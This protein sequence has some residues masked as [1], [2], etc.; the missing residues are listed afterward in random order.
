LNVCD[1]KIVF[2]T[3]LKGATLDVQEKDGN[4]FSLSLDSGHDSDLGMEGESG[5]RKK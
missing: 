2:I 5:N 4:I 3:L 1:R